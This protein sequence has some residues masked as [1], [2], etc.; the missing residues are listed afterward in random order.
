[1][2]KR[3]KKKYHYLADQ[4]K[5]PGAL[6]IGLWA[7]RF[8][9]TKE[10]S[11]TYRGNTTA[12]FA[13]WS[14]GIAA[15]MELIL[16]RKGK[17]VRS[18]ILGG[19]G[20]TAERSYSGGNTR[21]YKQYLKNMQHMGIDPDE[22]VDGSRKQLKRLVLAHQYAEG[23]NHKITPFQFKAAFVLLQGRSKNLAGTELEHVEIA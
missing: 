7:K 15:L 21:K 11:Y 19:Q 20:V 18:Y 12:V 1:M 9:A 14:H 22:V 13:T 3:D 17:T 5:S 4:A 8:G 16:N 6:N 10:N 2:F 23:G